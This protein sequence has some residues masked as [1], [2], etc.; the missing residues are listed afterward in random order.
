M[1]LAGNNI[2]GQFAVHWC[3]S[4]CNSSMKVHAC[5]YAW[6]VSRSDRDMSQHAW[7]VDIS[8]LSIG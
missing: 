2:I 5:E 6:R 7:A 4:L 8:V 1:N 3:L